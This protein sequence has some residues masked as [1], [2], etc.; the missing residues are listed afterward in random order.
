[1]MCSAV[2]LGV[3]GVL[4][5]FMPDAVLGAFGVPAGAPDMLLVQVLGATYFGFAFMNWMARGVLIG[6]IYARPLA[7][8]NF[9]HFMIAGLALGK[10]AIAAGGPTVLWAA[11]AVYTVFAV[12][13]AIVLFTHP[14]KGTVA[15]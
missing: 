4:C 11:T 10:H 13:F 3:C 9:A 1:M 15:D 8:G 6:G 7:L 14:S 12:I 2:V 5:E